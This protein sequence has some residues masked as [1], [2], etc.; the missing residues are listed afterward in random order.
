MGTEHNLGSSCGLLEPGHKGVLSCF[1]PEPMECFNDKPCT[2]VK[3]E[4][5]GSVLVEVEVYYIAPDG[6]VDAGRRTK[7]AAQFR[8]YAQFDGRYVCGA[9]GPLHPGSRRMQDEPKPETG[10]ANGT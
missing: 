8:A 10:V 3:A 1:S 5:D 9:L 4:A 2:V 7:G 6:R